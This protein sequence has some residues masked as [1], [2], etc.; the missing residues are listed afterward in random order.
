MAQPFFLMATD[1]SHTS[2]KT[3]GEESDSRRA[4]S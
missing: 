2:L 4:T 1:T 3:R